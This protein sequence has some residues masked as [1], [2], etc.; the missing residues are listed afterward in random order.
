LEVEGFE[1]GF[2]YLVS[3]VRVEV[4]FGKFVDPSEDF[5]GFESCEVACEAFSEDFYFDVVLYVC[6]SVV[7]SSILPIATLL[8]LISTSGAISNVN[9][10]V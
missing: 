4:C 9:S 3:A 8:T 5:C 1:Y 6:F 7:S 10:S 2:M